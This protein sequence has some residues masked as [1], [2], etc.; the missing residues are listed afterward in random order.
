MGA[1]DH[2]KHQ[3][4]PGQK[5]LRP[6]SRRRDP[7]SCGIHRQ[8]PGVPQVIVLSFDDFT[9]LLNDET[10]RQQLGA[11]LR[12]CRPEYRLG[13]VLNPTP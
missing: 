2:Q 8:V 7:E 4:H 12:E 9:Y 1:Y 11:I 5:Q 13:Q 3:L 6:G 10:Q